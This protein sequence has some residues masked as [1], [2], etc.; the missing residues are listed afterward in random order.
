[1]HVSTTEVGEMRPFLIAE[2]LRSNGKAC[3]PKALMALANLNGLLF[4]SCSIE[5][6]E[7]TLSLWDHPVQLLFRDRVIER[8]LGQRWNPHDELLKIEKCESAKDNCIRIRIESSGQLREF[9]GSKMDRS[10]GWWSLSLN[11]YPEI[12]YVA[13]DRGN[14]ISFFGYRQ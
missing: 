12:A 8:G 2:K 11:I 3:P 10:D 4:A 14:M 9:D 13:V 6:F 1:M 5:E 7:K